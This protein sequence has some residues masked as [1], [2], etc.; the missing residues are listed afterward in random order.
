MWS[1]WGGGGGLRI[2]GCL[3]EPEGR[4]VAQPEELRPGKL[5]SNPGTNSA[6]HF[7]CLLNICFSFSLSLQ[8]RFLWF[9]SH[10]AIWLAQIFQ[11]TYH[12]PNHILTI[13]ST[14]AIK[15]KTLTG[16]T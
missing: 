2:K 15:R 9:S 16:P 14:P 8:T 12:L 7:C 11:S 10:I 1:G 6:S 5:V 13:N 3:M 4:N